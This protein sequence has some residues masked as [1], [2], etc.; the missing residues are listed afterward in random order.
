MRQYGRINREDMLELTRRM[1]P[2]RNCFGRIAGAYF[3]AEGYVDGTFNRNFRQLTAKE[4]QKNLEI[5]KAIP[6]SETNV[7]LR[8]YLLE[9]TD[10]KTGSMWQMLMALRECELKN[11]AL[12]DI[13]YELIGETFHA[14]VPY[15]FYMFHGSYDIPRKGTDH[16]SQWESEEVYSFLIGACCKVSGDYEP[17]KPESGFLFPAF[18]NRSA[19]SSRIE[20]FCDGGMSL[21]DL[22]GGRSRR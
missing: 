2:A 13:L 8:E 5:A 1:T 6:F 18:R 9:E 21:A 16:E 4:Q 12:L 11:D 22:F 14:G 10:R 19:D 3:D 15:A 7:K 20:L 17:Q